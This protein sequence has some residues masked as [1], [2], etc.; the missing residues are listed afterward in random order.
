[1]RITKIIK[2]YIIKKLRVENSVPRELFE[3]SDYFRRFNSISFEYKKGDGGHLIAISSNFRYGTIVAS[4][5]NT[6]DLEENIKDAILTAFDVPSVYDK[7][8]NIKK[9]GRISK[10]YAFA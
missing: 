2:D 5:K 6:E 9:V 8:A 7:E 3:L 4:G 1:M 10:E